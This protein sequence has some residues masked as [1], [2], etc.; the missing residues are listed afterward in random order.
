MQILIVEDEPKLASTLQS[1]LEGEGYE[2]TVSPNGEDGYF[3]LHAQAFD[4]VLLDVMLPN[5]DGFEILAQLRQDG[6]RTPVLL[7]TARDTVED[8]VRGLD[9]GADDYMVKP[10]AFPELVARVRSLLRRG[11]AERSVKFHLAGLELDTS[12]HTVRRSETIIDLTARE[13][14]LLEYLFRNQ[15]SVVSRDTLAREIWGVAARESHIDNVIDVHVARLRR[16][17][18]DNFNPKLLQTVRGVGFVLREELA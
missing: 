11:Q 18:D 5:R 1:G 17:I 3:R 16:K 14:S 6:V 10:F 15:G 13:Y 12:S 7:L 9:H 8:R 4:L 2:V